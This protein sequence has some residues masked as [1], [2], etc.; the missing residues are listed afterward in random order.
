MIQPKNGEWLAASGGAR[1]GEKV[2]EGRGRKALGT[3]KKLSR[4]VRGR[5]HN[6]GERKGGWKVGH[7]KTKRGRR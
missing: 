6:G 7:R 1:K 2:A 5:V 3:Y 4:E